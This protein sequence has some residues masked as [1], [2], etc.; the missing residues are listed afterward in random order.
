MWILGYIYM[1]IYVVSLLFNMM[2]CVKRSMTFLN[3]FWFKRGKHKHTHTHTHDELMSFTVIR[4]HLRTTFR[5]L[6]IP[7]NCIFSNIG[8]P[9]L[10][11]TKIYQIKYGILCMNDVGVTTFKKVFEICRRDWLLEDWSHNFYDSISEIIYVLEEPI[12]II[13]WYFETQPYIHVDIL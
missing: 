2:V 4:V 13:S 1:Y 9:M 12:D 7:S 11:I 8:W 6:S 3:T 10:R 5:T